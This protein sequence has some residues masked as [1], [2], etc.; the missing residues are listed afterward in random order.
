MTTFLAVFFFFGFGLALFF[1]CCGLDADGVVAEG[2]GGRGLRLNTGEESDIAG[3]F[4][5]RTHKSNFE[6]V[7][8]VAT[9]RGS[10]SGSTAV[11][12]SVAAAAAAVQR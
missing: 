10:G 12:A 7:I 11:A 9:A 2:R 3:C 4:W 5:R 8:K 1:L 6:A